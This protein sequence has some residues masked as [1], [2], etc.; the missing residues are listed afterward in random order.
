MMVTLEVTDDV[1]AK[2]VELFVN[3]RP[4]P[5][6]EAKPIDV[7]A[8]PIDL[9][10]KG[11]APNHRVANELSFRF[12]LPQGQETIRVRAVA[13]D[14]TDLGSDPVE[15]V[16][17]RPGVTPVTGNLYVLSVGVSRYRNAGDR[18]RDLRFPAADAKAIAER[19]GREGPPLYGKVQVRTLVD[20]EATSVN[21]RAGLQWLQES[22]RPEQV[23]TTVI[24]LSGH[25]VN[26]DGRYYFAT[27][28]FALE[29]PDGTGLSGTELG[30]ALS[31]EL[32]AKAV[33]LFVDTCHSGAMTG[34]NDEL[35]HEVGPGVFMLTSSSASESSYES[36][37][38]EHGAFTKALLWSLDND[39]MV[40]DRQ[41]QFYELFGGVHKEIARL[42]EEAGQSSTVQTPR[43][44]FPGLDA[45]IPLVRVG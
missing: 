25:G 11:L 12:G 41:I 26:I 5:A 40:P 35:A 21:V 42:M 18:I 37:E 36:E 7:A 4:L 43:A 39:F 22:A 44:L 13:Y 9:A 24:F 33:F 17:K 3:G 2:D 27:H 23:D 38:C 45:T 28:D 6:A 31:A 8:K 14:E 10:A 15:I 19:F 29:D 20:G 16:L 32:R 34:S 30:E 1:G